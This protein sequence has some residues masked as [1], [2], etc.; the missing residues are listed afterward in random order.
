MDNGVKPAIVK[1]FK[2]TLNNESFLD[3]FNSWEELGRW[4]D[5]NSIRGFSAEMYDLPH[6]ISSTNKAADATKSTF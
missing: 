1:L 6:K 5:E 3:V 2:I 4:M